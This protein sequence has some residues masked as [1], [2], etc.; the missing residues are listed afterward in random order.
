MTQRARVRDLSRY[1]P[2]LSRPAYLVISATGPRGQLR[3][4][5]ELRHGSADLVGTVLLDE[6]DSA[7][8]GLGQVG[9]G[10]DEL[11]G[12]AVDD[13]ARLGLDEQLGQIAFGQPPAVSLDDRDD[14]GRL[15]VDRDVAWP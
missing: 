11:E 10:P 3:V 14:L 8:G 9:P 5:D 2:G 1:D 13:G 7:D 15:A 4:A 12:A 6:M